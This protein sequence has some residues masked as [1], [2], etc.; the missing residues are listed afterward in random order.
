MVIK[1][2]KKLKKCFFNLKC[3]VINWRDDVITP[4]YD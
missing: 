2:E 4:N 1:P 3:D